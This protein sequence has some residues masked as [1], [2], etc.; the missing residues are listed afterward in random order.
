VVRG[1]VPLLIVAVAALWMVVPILRDTPLGHDHPVHLFN[2]WHFWTEM[3]GRGRIHGWSHFLAFGYPPGEFMPFGPDLWVASFRIATLGALSWMKTYGLALAGVLVFATFSIYVFARRFFGAATAALAAVL[4]IADPGAWAEGGWEWY[5][6]YGVWP[7]TL[8]MSFTLLS[9]TKLEDVLVKGRRRDV[10][11]CAVFVLASLVTHLLPLVVYPIAITLLLLDHVL[12]RGGFPRGGLA[13]VAAAMSLGAGLAAFQIVPMLSRSSMTRD[14][15]V[16]GISLDE[17]GRRIVE[18]RVFENFW[19]LLAVLGMAGALAVLRRRLPGSAFFAS[20]V[21][22]FVVLSSDV[23]VSKLHLERVMPGIVKIEARRML[24]VAKLFWFVLAAAAVVA[25]V[26]PVGAWAA[27]SVKDQRWRRSPWQ[28]AVALALLGAVVVPLGKPVLKHLYNTQVDKQIQTKRTTAFWYDLASFCSWSRAERE[29][30]KDFYRIAY[31]LP[32]HDHLSMLASVFNNTMAY[33][34]G[35]TPAQ[36]F[37]NFPTTDEPE[38]YRAMS[39]KYVVSDH[40]LPASLFTSVV[41]FGVLSVYRFNDYSPTPFTLT[42][43]GAAE[44]VRFDDEEIRIRLHGTEPTSRLKLHVASYSRWEA[45]AN[46]TL[47]AIDTVPVYGLEYPILMEVPAIDGELVLRY[48]RRPADWLGLFLTLGAIA[49]AGFVAFERGRR[50]ARVLAAVAR[51]WARFGRAVTV[52]AAGLALVGALFVLWRLHSPALL[53]PPQSIFREGE[54][55]RMTA[56][57]AIAGNRCD[58][59]ET[60]VWQCGPYDL[61]ADV[62]SGIYGTH[63][64]MNAAPSY[65]TLVWSASVALGR[66][67]EGRYDPSESS[68]HIRVAIDGVEIGDMATRGID[69]GLQTIRFDTRAMAGRHGQVNIEITGAPLHC[70][71]FQII[72]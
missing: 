47:V 57:T 19:P 8:A 63:L 24:L 66:F 52:A 48:V 27:N 55:E 40:A 5:V 54:G 26:R 22:V 65:A 17:L 30:T 14:L 69:Q 35:Y 51:S 31:A 29:G 50:G 61:K 42:G 32:M 21:G 38:L 49:L 53:L 64:C 70:F 62:V 3:L 34:V 39:V 11:W 9:L 6:T 68:G 28:V 37:L 45:R 7:V 36:E 18:L 2:A 59:R 10:L 4:F 72:R 56:T 67:I 20:A 58:Q 25:L 46:G 43:P 41:T 13:R 44:V 1:A 71:D 60:S 33:K 23:L 15:G 16:A 12:R